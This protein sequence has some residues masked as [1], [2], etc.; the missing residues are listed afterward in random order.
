MRLTSFSDYTL[1]VLIYLALEP[2]RLVTIQSIAD[3]YD[4]SENH[5]MKV[6]HHLARAGLIETVR[7][8]G[9]GVRL[10][11]PAAEIR[12]GEVVRSTEGGTPIVEC[13]GD[14]NHCCITRSCALTGI[15]VAA[16]GKLYAYLDDYTLADLV[17]KPQPLQ[18]QLNIQP[19]TRI[20]KPNSA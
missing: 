14:D 16:F 7:G 1:R 2:E 13:L 17:L 9:G 15:L 11:R 12:L 19:L 5:L 6:V 10:A 18:R 3:G 4:I 20:Q 8:K